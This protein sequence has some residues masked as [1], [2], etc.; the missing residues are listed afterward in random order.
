MQSTV[1][2]ENIAFLYMFIGRLDRKTD[3]IQVLDIDFLD[4]EETK[5]VEGVFY[6]D[7]GSGEID[8]EFE[9]DARVFAIDDGTSSQIALLN[10]DDYGASA[11]EATYTIEGTYTTAKGKKSRRA[12]LSFSN[13]E[14]IQVLGFTSEEGSGSL[15]E[16]T[17]KR[18]D[19]FTITEH[20]MKNQ[21]GTEGAELFTKEG[22]TLVFGEDN[23]IWK[24][25]AAPR[26][27]YYIGFIAED[28]DG[29]QY[30]SYATVTR[31]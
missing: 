6:P 7:W 5:E 16:I 21:Q 26:G 10:P 24:D 27:Q 18:G 25:V 3:A 19:R 15:R 28:F 30:T 9:W 23:F 29:N 17:P 1:S 12:L 2:G 13:G 31:K 14:L 20:W 4:A 11:E 22:E 8:I